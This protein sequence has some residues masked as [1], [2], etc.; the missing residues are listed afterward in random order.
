VAEWSCSGLQSRVR[1]FDSDPSLH[2]SPDLSRSRRKTLAIAALVGAGV[3]ALG[4]TVQET[5]VRFRAP[6][7]V[8]LQFGQT[9][10]IR[11]LAVGRQGYGNSFSAEVAAGMG[12]VAAASETHFVVL[13]GDNF[14]PAGVDSVADGQWQ[15]KFERLY[16]AE[17]LRNL[18]F[19]PVLG[20]HDHAG[21]AAAQVAY[22]AERRGSGRWRMRG[23][24]Y[25]EDFGR[26]D[27]R[28]LLRIVFLDTV[29]MARSAWKRRLGER[30]LRRAMALPGGPVWRVVVGHAGVR[31]HSRLRFTQKLLLDELLPLMREL[32]V[33]LVLSGNDRL[34]QVLDV[35]G[36]PLHVS[37][38]GGG[39]KL[40][41]DVA[42][43]VS[44]R[45]FIAARP[46]FA[47]IVVDRGSLEVV[48]LD[49]R[50]TATY[51]K[52]RNR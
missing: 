18:P 42:G 20:N 30:Y 11:F 14:Y 5:W 31:S 29:P 25:H 45:T 32:E 19:F 15:Q 47:S 8:P 39:E 27:D 36:E 38:N 17:S 6:A 43:Q 44:D 22:A 16:R 21:N 33:D 12:R 49:R 37:T 41:P 34:Q 40:E 52:T 1:R 23:L 4:F 9:D 3:V 46:G 26:A 24:Q 2:A 48:M 13:T 50:G 28:V 35:H 51:R 10:R 7:P